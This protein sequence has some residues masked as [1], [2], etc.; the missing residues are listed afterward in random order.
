MSF[1]TGQNFAIHVL[2]K[3]WVGSRIPNKCL[4]WLVDL[5]V[6]LGWDFLG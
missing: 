1:A 5:L 2:R 4:D 6:G 3:A